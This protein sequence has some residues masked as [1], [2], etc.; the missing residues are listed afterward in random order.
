MLEKIISLITGTEEF[1]LTLVFLVLIA[2]GLGLPIPEDITIIASGILISNGTTTFMHSLVVC[3][4]GILVGDSIIYFL[5]RRWGL[6]LLKSKIFSK[7]INEKLIMTGENAFKKYGN[8]I[9]FFARF[10]PG[11]RAPIYFLSGSMKTPFTVFVIVDAF[12]ALISVPIWIYVGKLFG[13]NI[14]VLEKAIKKLQSGTLVIVLALI[15]LLIIAH[16]LKKK[17]IK[18]INS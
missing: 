2:C 3:M 6:S 1:G 9:L 10:L 12:A 5:G 16:F 8:K 18:T 13:D 17:L 15:V 14:A 7:I 4:L 11:L